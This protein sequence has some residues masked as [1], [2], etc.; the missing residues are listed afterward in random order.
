MALLEVGTIV[1]SS[2]YNLGKVEGIQ[3]SS[4]PK[5]GGIVGT[6]Q[7]VVN[8]CNAGEVIYEGVSAKYVGTLVG[9]L[10]GSVTNSYT[11]TNSTLNGIGRNYTSSP[12]PTKVDF[13]SQMPTVLEIVGD[14]FKED[15]NNINDGY[16]LLNWQ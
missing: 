7:N 15:A 8:C 9:S 14:A 10:T 12:E 2:C 4:T 3:T 5:V 11:L 13:V 16:P 6:V 1:I